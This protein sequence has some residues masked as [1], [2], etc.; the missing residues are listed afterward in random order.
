MTKTIIS[1]CIAL[2]GWLTPKPSLVAPSKALFTNLCISSW[3][4]FHTRNVQRVFA[5][6]LVLLRQNRFVCPPISPVPRVIGSDLKPNA[7][8]VSESKSW[9]SGIVPGSTAALRKPVFIDGRRGMAKKSR[10]TQKAKESVNST[11]A[12]LEHGVEK[13]IFTYPSP[14]QFRILSLL[15]GTQLMFWLG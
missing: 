5:P 8:A 2:R 15:A 6:A 12:L 11:E 9:S 14:N 4:S 3:R 7:G 13:V 1:R 10:A